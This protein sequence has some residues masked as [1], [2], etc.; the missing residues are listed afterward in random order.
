VNQHER[1]ERLAEAVIPEAIEWVA[2]LR[3]YRVYQGKD[4][5]Y[6][7]KARVGLGVISSGVRLCATIENSRTN[8]LVETRVKA[9]ESQAG[10]RALTDGGRA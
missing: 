1:L 10:G 7:K 5:E 8:D 3:K 9:L 4:A 6:F 2:E